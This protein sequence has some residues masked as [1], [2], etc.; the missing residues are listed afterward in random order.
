MEL[1]GSGTESVIFS[2]CLFKHV[3]SASL[4]TC[5]T[6]RGSCSARRTSRSGSTGSRI[7]VADRL[8]AGGPRRALPTP[9]FCLRRFAKA[10]AAS[11]V[12]SANL[13]AAARGVAGRR[14]RG[15]QLAHADTPPTPSASAQLTAVFT[16][17]WVSSRCGGLRLRAL[18]RWRGAVRVS[19][20]SQPTA[21]PYAL[22]VGS[23][24]PG[25]VA[26][27][28][29]VLRGHQR[30]TILGGTRWAILKGVP[31][32]EPPGYSASPIAERIGKVRTDLD[33]FYCGRA[34]CLGEPRLLRRRGRGAPAAFRGR[35]P[36][37]AWWRTRRT[38]SRMDEDRVRHALRR[39]DH[40]ISLAPADD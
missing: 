2:A 11:G 17:T 25:A 30:P 39:S 13:R 15:R 21:T 34:V 12:L 5:P 31:V 10:V 40:R 7:A 6:A 28:T 16:T 23:H 38:K 3:S 4:G 35:S 14:L 1:G 29:D 24:E 36:M 27:P 19:R 37:M 26:A 22:H 18:L 20:H 9:G 8:G 33:R 32:D